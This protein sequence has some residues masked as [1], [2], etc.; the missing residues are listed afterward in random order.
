MLAVFIK[1]NC[2][3]TAFLPTDVMCQK[4]CFSP[5]T[6]SHSEKQGGGVSN[7]WQ[8]SSHC[9]NSIAVMELSPILPSFLFSIRSLGLRVFH[10]EPNICRES[11][12]PSG[13]TAAF[14]HRFQSNVTVFFC[15]T[16]LK[17]I[18]VACHVTFKCD[19][20]VSV[21]VLLNIL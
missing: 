10:F 17:N 14:L 20:S 8:V 9:S 13:Y 11:P 18:F 2:E 4:T 12:S 3:M 19:K 21:S 7:F 15:L 16:T 1:P 5:L 6:L